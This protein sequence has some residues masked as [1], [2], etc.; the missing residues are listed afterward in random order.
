MHSLATLAQTLLVF[1]PRDAIDPA[2]DWCV[3]SDEFE[4]MLTVPRFVVDNSSALFPRLSVSSEAW[5]QRAS[6]VQ[7]VHALTA[8]QQLDPRNQYH[9]LQHQQWELYYSAVDSSTA[10]VLMD[11]LLRYRYID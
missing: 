5:L 1:V 10:V 9:A 11:T 4:T 6:C 3:P 2:R 8:T 7:S